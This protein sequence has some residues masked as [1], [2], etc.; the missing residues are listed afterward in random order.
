MKEI[1][2]RINNT[3]ISDSNSILIST[4]KILEYFVPKKYKFNTTSIMKINANIRQIIIS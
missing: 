4:N 1:N 3:D 2:G